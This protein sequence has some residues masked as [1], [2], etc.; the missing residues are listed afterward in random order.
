MNEERE[1]GKGKRKGERK[2]GK[3]GGVG[4]GGLKMLQGYFGPYPWLIGAK[5]YFVRGQ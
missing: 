4:K 5:S 2:G 1:K 3:S